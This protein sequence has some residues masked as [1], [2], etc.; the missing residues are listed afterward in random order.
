[1]SHLTGP[2]LL[3]LRRRIYWDQDEGRAARRARGR[4]IADRHVS[5]A[6]RELGCRVA[7]AGVSLVQAAENLARVGPLAIGREGLRELVEGEGRA[8][9]AQGAAGPR[10][11][12][13]G[14]PRMV[15][16]RTAAPRGS[17]WVATG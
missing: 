7:T 16:G 17:W 14:R 5:V 11:A 1:M 13:L 9:V 12:R 8:A 15:R 4:G 3:R 6:A 2:G 10:A